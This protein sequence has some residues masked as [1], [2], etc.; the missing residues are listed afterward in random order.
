MVSIRTREGRPQPYPER[1]LLKSGDE[2]CL[3]QIFALLHVTST[4]DSHNTIRCRDRYGRISEMGSSHK[5]TP[6]LHASAPS[7]PRFRPKRPFSVFRGGFPPQCNQFKR[8]YG[9]QAALRSC[10]QAQPRAT[11]PHGCHVSPSLAMR[12]EHLVM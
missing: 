7:S 4:H 2:G 1:A 10:G 11:S 5:N 9:V 8:T 3:G 6:L 12:V